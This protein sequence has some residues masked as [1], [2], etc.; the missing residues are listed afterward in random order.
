MP[1][2]F[3]KALSQSAIPTALDPDHS[4]AGNSHKNVHPAALSQTFDRGQMEFLLPGTDFHECKILL[5]PNRQNA[6]I[7]PL[8]YPDKPSLKNLSETGLHSLPSRKN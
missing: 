1:Q 3:Y 5:R 7:V 8:G 6:S 4:A 2:P